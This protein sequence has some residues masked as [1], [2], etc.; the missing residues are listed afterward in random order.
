[1]KSRRKCFSTRG[2]Y[3]P[4]PTSKSSVPVTGSFD[5]SQASS[6][7][8][9]PAPASGV[10]SAEDRELSSSGSAASGVGKRKKRRKKRADKKAKKGGEEEPHPSQKFYER[11]EC[12]FI[13]LYEFYRYLKPVL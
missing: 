7:S 3:G 2:V 11:L 10:G 8:L 5:G 12:L 9:G 13:S 6:Q 4:K 1:M